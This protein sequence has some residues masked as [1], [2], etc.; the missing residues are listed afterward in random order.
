MDATHIDVGEIFDPGRHAEDNSAF[1]LVPGA[2]FDLRKGLNLAANAR[3][4]CW[5]AIRQEVPAE[6]IG[7]PVCT[8]PEVTRGPSWTRESPRGRE[9]D[10][11][12]SA[13][14]CT[15]GRWTRELIFSTSIRQDLRQDGCNACVQVRKPKECQW[16]HGVTANH[17]AHKWG[18]SWMTSMKVLGCTLKAKDYKQG[19]GT[20]TTSSA[21]IRYSPNLVATIFQAI[22]EHVRIAQGV[23]AIEVEVVSTWTT[24]ARSTARRYGSRIVLQLDSNGVRAA[25]QEELDSAGETQRIESRPMREA[26]DKMGRKP[27]CCQVD[28]LQQGRLGGGLNCD[29]DCIDIIRELPA[30]M[31]SISV[32]L[33]RRVSCTTSMNV[34]W[35]ARRDGVGERHRLAGKTKVVQDEAKSRRLN[36]EIEQGPFSACVFRRGTRTIRQ[37]PSCRRS[38]KFNS[39]GPGNKPTGLQ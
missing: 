17:V 1:D 34:S 37:F 14:Q 25:R 6:T 19:A 38:W 5:R 21:L 24:R 30:A 31:S 10:T 29:A 12:S 23:K 13:V 26:F 11:W 18:T 32:V 15:D 33:V 7:S 35:S 36:S 28:R 20:S 8:T 27:F 2:V 3:N 16:C 39:G 22:T 9:S 4:E